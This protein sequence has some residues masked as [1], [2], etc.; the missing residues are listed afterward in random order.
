[1]FSIGPLSK[2]HSLVIP[3]YHAAHLHELPDEYLAE[4]LPIAKKLAIASGAK[5]YNVLQ[6]NGRGAHQMVDHVHVHIIPKPN[7]E[8][9]L[10]VGWPQLKL[11]KE[12]LQ[13]VSE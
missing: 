2:G 4:L 7:E 3:K 12:E 13:K 9:G 5:E 1:M 11:E 6:N 8:Q 10:G